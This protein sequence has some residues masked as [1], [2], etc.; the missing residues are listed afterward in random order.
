MGRWE[1]DA[2]G[3]LRRAALELFAEQGYDAT[4]VAEIAERAGVTSRTFFR[5]FADK[6]E[7]LFAGAEELPGRM[8]DAVRAA[9][10]GL[11]PLDLVAAGLRGAAAQIGGSRAWSRERS[12]IIAGQAELQERELHK[13]AGVG[14]ALADALRERGLD[15]DTVA[16]AA[17]TGVAVFR[18]GFQRW[19]TQTEEADLGDVLADSLDRL[20]SLAGR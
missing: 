14:A 19:L 1:P 12:R 6:R 5:H 9:P 8:A 17:E 3:R 4:T 13:M 15:D 7:V 10:A 11:A 20:R 2:A 16:V 18:V